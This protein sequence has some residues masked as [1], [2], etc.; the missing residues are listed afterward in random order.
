[1]RATWISRDGNQRS[2]LMSITIPNAEQST[3]LQIPVTWRPHM[4]RIGSSR[5]LQGESVAQKR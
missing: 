1:V 3:A 5:K 2:E 4:Q